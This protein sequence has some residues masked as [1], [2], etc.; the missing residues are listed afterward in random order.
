MGTVIESF[1]DRVSELK[2]QYAN[3]ISSG[4]ATDYANYQKLCGVLEGIVVAEREIKELLSKAGNE[5]DDM[6]E[7]N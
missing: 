4:T 1:L 6:T 3:H 5:V 2:V 7:L